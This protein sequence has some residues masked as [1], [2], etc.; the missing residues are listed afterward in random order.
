[1]WDEKVLYNLHS[2]QYLLIPIAFSDDL[3][4]IAIATSCL[5]CDSHRPT[6]YFDFLKTAV[7]LVIIA[8]YG[9]QN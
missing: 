4:L 9:F 5:H 1:M 7:L 3:D 6:K 2:N 8:K